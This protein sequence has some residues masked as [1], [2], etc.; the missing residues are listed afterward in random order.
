MIISSLEH[1]PSAAACTSIRDPQELTKDD[2]FFF[3]GRLERAERSSHRLE[4]ICAERG[5][6]RA[7]RP[8]ISSKNPPSW[9]LVCGGGRSQWAW[10]WWWPPRWW[11]RPRCSSGWR[12]ETSCIRPST[13][14]ATMRS[15]Y[16]CVYT[17]T[18][19]SKARR[20]EKSQRRD[21]RPCGWSERYMYLL[22]IK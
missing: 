15:T 11:W 9:R 18:R 17:C 7:S 1:R 12:C 20:G 19:P 22:I 16:A 3:G 5:R 6:R 21:D 2:Q 10:R 14:T 13:S 4:V 8:S